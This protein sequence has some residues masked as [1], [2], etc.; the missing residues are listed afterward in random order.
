MSHPAL[1]RLLKS[2]DCENSLEL[3]GSRLSGS[4]ATSLLMEAMARRSGATAASEVLSQYRRDRFT[5][6]AQVDPVRLARL[7]LRALELLAPSFEPVELS[8]LAP[9]G[10]HSVV[11]GVHQNNVVS[12]VRM[13]EVAA[14][15]TNQLALEVAV[16]RLRQLAEDVRSQ[17]TVRLC[18]VSRVMRAQMFDGPRSFAHFSLLGVVMGGRDRGSQRFEATALFEV[19]RAITSVLL[20]ASQHRVHVALSDFDGR[21]GQVL[22]DVSTRIGGKR[23][24]CSADP[25]RQAGRGYYPNI[26]F[27]LAMDTGSEIVEVGDG[28]FVDWSKA[29]LQ[30]QKERLLTGGVSLERLAML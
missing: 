16:R 2:A 3:F 15:P 13:S 12:T 30:N 24:T 17:E 28:G 18:S 29:L 26:C 10:T 11:A 19:I 22:D 7:H 9:L 20:D 6:P 21:F 5:A 23:V 27:K 1:A 8:P 25:H 4:D 14:D